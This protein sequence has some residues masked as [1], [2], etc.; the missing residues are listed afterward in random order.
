VI[1]APWRADKIS[2]GNVVRDASG[3]A[4][5]HIIERQ[6]HEDFNV[7][8]FK[9]KELGKVVPTQPQRA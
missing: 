6:L 5:A 4:L 3:Q 9:D 7:H 1:P 8:D 2:R